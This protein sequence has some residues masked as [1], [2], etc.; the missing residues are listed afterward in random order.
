MLN[1]TENYEKTWITDK[2]HS[3]INQFCSKHSLQE[4]YIEIFDKLD[5]ELM[6]SLNRDLE[7]W[8]PGIEILSVR[9]TKPNIP[10]R[11]KKNFEQMEKVKVDYYIA[12]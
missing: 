12:T 8:A 10:E 3:E 1:Y 9:V 7:K 5:E 6:T 4:I 11:I 2:I